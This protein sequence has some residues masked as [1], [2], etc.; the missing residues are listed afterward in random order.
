MLSSDGVS[1]NKTLY[2]GNVSCQ[3]KKMQWF[4]ATNGDD[5]KPL[6]FRQFV[7]ATFCGET[8]TCFFW[9]TESFLSGVFSSSDSDPLVSTI[10]FDKSETKVDHDD[11]EC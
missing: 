10:S 6:N 3:F 5:L 2:L 4:E 8:K 9:K 7:K 11:S 1:T